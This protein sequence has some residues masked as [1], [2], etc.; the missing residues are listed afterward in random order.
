MAAGPKAAPAAVPSLPGLADPLEPRHPHGAVLPDALG[1][2]GVGAL[3][4]AMVVALHRARPS[5]RLHC[6][7]RNAQALAALQTRVPL[8]PQ[9]SNQA[10]ADACQMVLIGVRPAQLQALAGEVQFN[11]SHHLLV[12]TAGTPLA[13]LQAL[14]APARVT[15]LMTGLAVEGGRSAISC[16]PPHDGVQA[17][18]QPACAAVVPFEHEAQFEASMLLICV[19]AWWLDQL[20]A[21]SAWLV[22]ATGMQP[23]QAQTL[24]AANMADV[25]QLLALH[26]DQGAAELARQIGSP[27]TYTAAGLDHLQAV[28]AHQPWL[29]ALALL[30]AR[31]PQAA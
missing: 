20:G 22:Q 15:R 13:T 16:H 19:N 1:V 31:L 6:A 30:R 14:F 5:L 24:L 11:A 27:G 21:L 17:L 29:D 23:Q 26:P 10:V 2:L 3:S 8:T 4:S 12:L 18:W 25:A 28:Q 7:P 9:A